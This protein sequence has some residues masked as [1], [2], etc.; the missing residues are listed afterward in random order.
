MNSVLNHPTTAQAPGATTASILPGRFSPA[1]VV[2]DAPAASGAVCEDTAAHT[3]APARAG[4]SISVYTYFGAYGYRMV[5]VA[6]VQ[7]QNARILTMALPCGEMA[8]VWEYAYGVGVQVKSKSVANRWYDV[9][10]SHCQCTRFHFQHHCGHQRA[11]DEAIT[12][13]RRLNAIESM[14][15]MVA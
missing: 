12:V 3:P 10:R 5:R 9:T 14:K 2:V 1:G 8:R 4:E 11:A 7:R 13:W 6:S 15:G